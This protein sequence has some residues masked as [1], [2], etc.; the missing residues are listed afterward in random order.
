M[1]VWQFAAAFA[2]AAAAALIIVARRW[3]P[4]QMSTRNITTVGILVAIGTVAASFVWV[5]VGPAKAYPGQHAINVL[6]AVLLGPV[7]ATVVALL[8]GIL[9]MLMGIGT[10]LALPGGMFGAFFAGVAY[11][12]GRRYEFAVVGEVVGTGIVGAMAA[13]PIVRF[14][15]GDEMLAFALVAPFLLSSGV[16][17][18]VAYLMLRSV[19]SIEL[20]RGR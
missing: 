20:W 7:P 16:G 15:L 10:V 8:V 1:T 19:E 11:R 5:P 12:L 3:Y 2:L 14:V 13:V 17:A 6:A 4:M 18:V 9:R